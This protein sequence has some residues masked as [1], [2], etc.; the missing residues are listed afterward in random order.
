MYRYFFW[1]AAAVIFGYLIYYFFFKSTL[2][3][4]QAAPYFESTNI[5]G[6]HIYLKQFKGKYLLID[7]W[8][9]WCVPCRKENPIML[10]MYNK[11][12][13]K[14]YKSASGI[15]FLSVALDA[16]DTEARTAI[17]KDELVWPNQIIE[18]EQLNSPIA[19]LYNVSY[20]P[21]KYLIGP[22]QI[23][24]LVNPNIRELDDF[25]A[26]QVLKN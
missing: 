1:I 12:K 6:Q 7:F 25:L 21:M 16:N 2:V 11:Y 20:I 9:S 13:N 19:K 14:P 8:G 5:N 23:I 22:D 26:Y 4:G 3:F 10:M 18:K 15:E 24:M 17:K